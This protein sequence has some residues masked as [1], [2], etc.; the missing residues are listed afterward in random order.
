[1]KCMF[2]SQV[3]AALVGTLPAS[4]LHHRPP[5]CV[6]QHW[7]T[8]CFLSTSSPC[9]PQG[10]CP[11]WTLCLPHLAI[12]PELAAWLVSSCH[13]WGLVWIHSSPLDLHSFTATCLIFFIRSYSFVDLLFIFSYNCLKSL[14]INWLAHLTSAYTIEYKQ[15][16]CPFCSPLYLR[17]WRPNKMEILH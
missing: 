17:A 2:V 7:P 1:M 9:P 4:W 16:A 5:H 15:A 11:C 13:G 12:P 3:F 6:Q 10:R 14:F 8:S